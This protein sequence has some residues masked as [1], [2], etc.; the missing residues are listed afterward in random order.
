VGSAVVSLVLVGD[1]AC[2]AGAVSYW[3]M[4]CKRDVDRIVTIR[5]GAYRKPPKLLCE[6][7]AKKWTAR[8]S[9]S[10]PTSA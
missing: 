10:K 7:C 1:L 9:T 5:P 6:E 8:Q 4:G 3:C 2:L